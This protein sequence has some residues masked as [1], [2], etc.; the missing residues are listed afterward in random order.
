MDRR[1][2]VRASSGM[3]VIQT[4]GVILISLMV[5]AVG[6]DF[7]YYF[8]E[9]N[10]LQTAADAAALAAASE[11]YRGIA[12]DPDE[13]LEDAR[14]AARQ[15]VTYNEPGL[16]LAD[17]DIR[18][19]FINP[20]GKTYDPD[21]FTTPSSN[22]DYAMTKGY[23]AVFVRMDRSQGGSNSPLNSLLASLFG[24][25][26]MNT[27]AYAVAMVDQTVNAIT[28][29]G[30]RP[31]YACEGQVKKAMEDGILEN[32]LVRIYGDHLEVDGIGNFAQC[33]LPGSGNWGFADFTN[34]GPGTV[35]SSTISDWFASGYPGTVQIGTCYSTK[36]GNFISSV[37]GQLDKLILNKTV[38]PIP[39]YDTWQ[40]GGANTQV[41]IS[42]FVGFR[43]TGYKG[44]GPAASR[45]MEG[46]FTRYICNKGCKANSSGFSTLGGAAVKLRLASRS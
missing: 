11:L 30:L 24:V 5:S 27:G 22:P 8:A 33:P 3:H 26:T 12:V 1:R 41:N 20:A 34:C 7:S 37:S 46:H 9:Q 40:G 10:R 32:N 42:G 14:T 23:N 44:N 35:G 21:H 25:E 31:I 6:V 2:F 38:F 39:F 18:F 4:L 28:N 29:G 17:E 36:P 19:G 13:R 43:M 16:T 15:F 45:Y